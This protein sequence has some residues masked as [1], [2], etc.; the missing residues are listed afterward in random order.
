LRTH[1]HLAQCPPIQPH[2]NKATSF[3][4][5]PQPRKTASVIPSS[6]SKKNRY[7]VRFGSDTN[8]GRGQNNFLNYAS[9]L[10]ATFARSQIP[11][12]SK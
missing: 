8:L 6:Q 2:L 9:Q 5:S 3:W 4:A 10:Q 1:T 11:K 7:F 12:A